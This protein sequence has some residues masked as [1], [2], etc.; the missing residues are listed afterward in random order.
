[1]IPRVI[2]KNILVKK[3]EKETIKNGLIIPPSAHEETITCAIVSVGSECKEVTIGNTVL[4]MG[5]RGLAITHDEV[6]YI[7]TKEE[8]ILAII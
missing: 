4:L 8:D 3:I 5:Y 2:G 1:M 7:L 6:K